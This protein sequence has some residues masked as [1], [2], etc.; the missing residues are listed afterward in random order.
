MAVV[1]LCRVV[2]EAG[3]DT[4]AT[5]DEDDGSEDAGTGMEDGHEGDDDVPDKEGCEVDISSRM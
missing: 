2:A 5:F 3:N 4:D 1:C